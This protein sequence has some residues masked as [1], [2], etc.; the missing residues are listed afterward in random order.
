ML[1]VFHYL[2]PI[3]LLSVTLNAA[4]PGKIPAGKTEIPFEVPLKAKLN[5][6]LYETYHG[7]FVNVQVTFLFGVAFFVNT[8]S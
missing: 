7:V 8:H 3:P 4:K 5:K 1:Y 6:T 2:Q